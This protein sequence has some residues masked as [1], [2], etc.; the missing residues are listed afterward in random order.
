MMVHGNGTRMNM[1]MGLIDGTV[2][3]EAL[4]LTDRFIEGLVVGKV[5]CSNSEGDV[6]T[7]DFGWQKKMKNRQ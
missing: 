7:N 5:L 6:M 4:G 2:L 3:E 1:L